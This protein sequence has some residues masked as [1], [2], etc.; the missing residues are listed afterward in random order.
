MHTISLLLVVLLGRSGSGLLG[1]NVEKLGSYNIDKNAISVSGLSSGGFMAAQIHVIESKTFMGV[2]VIAGGPYG[3]SKGQLATAL[4]SC[5]SSPYMMNVANLVT[6][7]QQQADSGNIDPLENLANTKV[8]LYSGTLDSTVLPN[9]VKKT[10]DF[11]TDLSVKESSIFYKSDLDNVHGFPTYDEG[12]A[13]NKVNSNEYINKCQYDTAYELLNH[14]YRD[15]VDIPRPSYSLTAPA[16][17]G[18]FIT[19]DQGE[20]TVSPKSISMDEIGYLFVPDSCADGAKVCKLHV[21][22]H[23]CHQGTSFIGDSYATKTGYNEVAALNDIIVLYPQAT[24]TPLDNPNGCWDFWAYTGNDYATHQGKQ[25]QAVMNMV[26]RLSEGSTSIATTNPPLPITTTD[27]VTD[28]S[29]TTKSTAKSTSSTGGG[30]GVL[31]FYNADKS[32]VSVSGLSSGGFMAIQMHVAESDNIMGVGAVA[33]GPYYC[34]MNNIMV[35]TTYCMSTP[36]MINLNTIFSDT[37]DFEATGMIANLGNLQNQNVYLYSGSK[38]R[39]VSKGVV[40]K[41][42]AFYSQYSANVAEEYN[43]A[44]RDGFPTVNKGGECGTSNLHNLNRCEFAGAF[45]ILNHIYGGTLKMPDYYSN[46]AVQ[47]ELY[48]FSQQEVINLLDFSDAFLSDTGMVFVPT[49]CSSGGT[50]C[51]VHVAFHG[52]KSG[53]DA[54]AESFANDAGYNEVAALNDIIVIY[55][56]TK[57]NLL[58]NPQDCWD[59]WG[60]T[61]ENYATSEGIQIQA[62]MAMINR[63]TS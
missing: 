42:A 11:Y 4:T 62:V 13:C 24:S 15:S 48:E 45:N 63:V 55:P 31:G 17:K 57:I 21:S 23:G 51:R 61:N 10:G 2:G 60:Y 6:N 8:Y 9:V 22:F 25:T 58:V 59:W 52:C 50:A 38:D 37:Q 56:R 3:C 36:S 14:I 43:V 53:S 44:S 18:T 7:A 30:D 1:D 27:P 12:T 47:G 35:A 29:S 33:G 20:F 16:P 39:T 49:S 34:A 19:F 41:A 26:S 46:D 28:K 5:M 54:I 32:A 40:E